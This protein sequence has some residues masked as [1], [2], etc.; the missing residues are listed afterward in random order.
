MITE[1]QKE[2]IKLYVMP[3]IQNMSYIS[4]LINNSNDMD[5]LID[6]VLKLMNED[7]E[8]STKTDLKILYEK[9]TEQLK[10]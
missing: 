4:E 7:I 9:L 1:E 8:L 2:D 5:D 3:Y 6:K 10:E